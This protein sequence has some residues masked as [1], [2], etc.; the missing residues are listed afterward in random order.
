MSIIL[1]ADIL[2]YM[3]KE[4]YTIKDFL[5]LI[6]IFLIILLVSFYLFLTNDQSV[7]I[8]MR[9]FMAGFFLVF[10]LLKILKLSAFAEAY[11]MYDLLAQKSIGYAYLYPFIELGLGISYATNINPLFTNWITLFLML[12][13]ALGVY[14][15]LRKGEKI[16]CACL[17]TVFKVPMTWVTLFE[18][19]LMAAMAGIMLLML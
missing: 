2:R 11:R 13:S 19:L 6:S 12:I 10:G 4:R 16:L 18:D 1:G 9:S 8:G 15:Q 5:P 3:I 7:E 17:G 14:L